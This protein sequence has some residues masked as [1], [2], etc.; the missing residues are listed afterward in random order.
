MQPLPLGG[1][2]T[3]AAFNPARARG[4]IVATGK[5]NNAWLQL[6]APIVGTIQVE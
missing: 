1:A 3:S 6:V 2:L 4:P 5:F